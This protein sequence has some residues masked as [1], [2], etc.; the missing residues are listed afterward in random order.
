[1]VPISGGFSAQLVEREGLY[2][3]P[4]GWYPTAHDRVRLPICKKREGTT[5]PLSIGR[6]FVYIV[7]FLSALIIVLGVIIIVWYIIMVASKS[8]PLIHPDM[9]YSSQ[10]TA[11][12]PEETTVTLLAGMPYD[13]FREGRSSE[14]NYTP[15]ESTR[16]RAGPACSYR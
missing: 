8:S 3:C 13:G 5:D 6:R 11:F 1:M 16:C 10:K 7:G 14:I 15:G 2:Y 12:L 9:K 4:Q